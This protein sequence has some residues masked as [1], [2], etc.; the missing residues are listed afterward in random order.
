[1]P[2][3]ARGGYRG[4]RGTTRASAELSGGFDAT[5]AIAFRLYGPDDLTCANPAVFTDRVGVPAN[6]AGDYPSGSFVPAPRQPTGGC[7]QPPTVACAPSSTTADAS[8]S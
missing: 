1:M 7:A 8:S 3:A 5:G 2:E 4:T 6:V